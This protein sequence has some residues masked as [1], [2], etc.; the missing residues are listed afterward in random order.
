MPLILRPSGEYFKFIGSAYIHGIVDW[1]SLDDARAKQD[2]GYD[3]NG[4]AWLHGI[5]EEDLPFPTLEVM[6]V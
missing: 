1:E 5:T 4:T 2:P 6:I 3:R